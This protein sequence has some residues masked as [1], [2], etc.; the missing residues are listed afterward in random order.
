MLQ[1]NLYEREAAGVCLVGEPTEPGRGDGSE[2]SDTWSA[3]CDV[4]EKTATV[5]G[6]SPDLRLDCFRNLARAK[7][8]R[9]ILMR[10]GAL[11][12]LSL[13]SL[14]PAHSETLFLQSQSKDSLSGSLLIF[15]T[16]AEVKFNPENPGPG[17]IYASQ[18]VALKSVTLS[19]GEQLAIVLPA[20]KPGDQISA[21]LDS[22]RDFLVTMGPGEGEYFS[23]KALVWK[24]NAS[25]TLAL[26]SSKHVRRPALPD[27]MQERKLV[28][29]RLL[30]AGF[31][32]EQS[33]V[34]FLVGLPP[35][36]AE[37]QNNYGVLYVSSGFNGDR[38][39]YLNRY[40]VFYQTMVKLGLPL[41]L[42]SLDSSGDFGHHLFLDSEVNGPR[43]Q[44]L[45]DEIVPFIDREFRTIAS[46]KGRALYGHSSGAWTAV[47]LLRHFPET[48]GTAIATS[49]DPLH[50][51]PWWLPDSSNVY[52]RGDGTEHLLSKGLTLRAFVKPELLS[53]CAG[54]IA[55]FQA[56]FSP[57]SGDNY[58]PM[59]DGDSGEVDLEVWQQWQEQN[60][61][62]LWAKQHPEQAREAFANRLHLFV[63]DQDEF[64]LA[65]PTQE[66]SALLSQLE[67]PHQ[68]ELQVGKTHGD[69]IQTETFLSEIWQMAYRGIHR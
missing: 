43:G 36:Y 2:K 41:I 65:P 3:V 16:P 58:R 69:Y 42:V 19:P 15:V 53:G 11:V 1:A 59:F 68:F 39:T 31:S 48:F 17:M 24:S 29:Q 9:S 18:L 20:L 51:G 27:W 21:Y 23:Q 50:L 5:G 55:G 54:Q 34:R 6:G 47:S 62:Y 64:G 46:A 38:Y 60:D 10:L 57:A 35:G 7:H 13:A 45:N 14:A 56:A 32:A 40:K 28:S 66:F 8:M 25:E 49:P 44:V 37:G 63:G 22:K 52:Q 67:I 12:C 30:D 26:D 4:P 61:L 33:T